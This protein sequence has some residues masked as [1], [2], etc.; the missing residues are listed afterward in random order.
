MKFK[1]MSLEE[2][3][4]DFK[5]ILDNFTT[6]D[7]VDSLKEYIINKQDFQYVLSKKSN[8][9]ENYGLNE[10]DIKNKEKDED[11]YIENTVLEIE[12][13]EYIGMEEAA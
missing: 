8:L 6:S 13:N 9:D 3:K 1:E 4:K 11:E 5:K 10:M 7:L 2:L 12:N